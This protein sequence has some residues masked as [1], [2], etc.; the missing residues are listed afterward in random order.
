MLLLSSD[1]RMPSSYLSHVTQVEKVTADG[2]NVSLQ[3]IQTLALLD[4]PQLFRER[5]CAYNV[6]LLE[7]PA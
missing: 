6:D 1:R 5:H 4:E 3:R 2:S 7:Q